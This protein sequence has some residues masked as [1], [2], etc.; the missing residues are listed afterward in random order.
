MT[1]ENNHVT[2]EVLCGDVRRDD[3]TDEDIL[4]SSQQYDHLDSSN[5]DGP[6]PKKRRSGGGG[7]R[8]ILSDD[9]ANA[10]VAKSSAKRGHC[11]GD[12]GDEEKEEDDD[13]ND[14]AYNFPDADDLDGDKTPAWL[15]IP[16]NVW[17]R[18]KSYKTVKSCFGRQMVV[19][20]S[21]P[22]FPPLEL[23]ATPILAENLKIHMA[24]KKPEQS[25]FVLVKGTKDSKTSEYSY[26]DFAYK[27]V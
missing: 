17:Y 14:E 13:D 9:D 3:N 16:R 22:D 10:V 7:T 24:S 2:A 15:T 19:K 18:V 26:I 11:S 27:A 1:T 5:D 25:I 4:E 20:I 21:R 8:K 23:F 6:S 12:D